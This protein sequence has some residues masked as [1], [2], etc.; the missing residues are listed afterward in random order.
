MKTNS[1]NVSVNADEQGNAIRVSK[2]NPEYG[3]VRLTQEKVSFNT[4]GWVNRKVLST[5]VHGK[6]DDL[7]ALGFNPNQEMPGNIVV[8]EQTE[9]FSSNDPERDLKIAGET[10]IVCCAHGEQ[11]YRKTFYD[12][13]GI[14]ND[15]LVAHTNADAIREANGTSNS[16]SMTQSELNEVLTKKSDKKAKREEKIEEPKEESVEVQDETFEL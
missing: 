10:G 5:L 15:L 9:A 12:A 16:N 4:Q 1:S 3:H 11:I 14:E 13:S 7:Q 8:R 2:N 6:V